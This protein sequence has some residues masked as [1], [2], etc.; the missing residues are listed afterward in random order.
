MPIKT[1][2][3]IYQGTVHSEKPHEFTGILKLLFGGEVTSGNGYVTYALPGVGAWKVYSDVG[4]TKP[5]DHIPLQIET[6]IAATVEKI[7]Q[8]APP[9][10]VLGEEGENHYR[11][12][13][14]KSGGVI[15]GYV[16]LANR[17]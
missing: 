17:S 10:F 7:R 8:M 12:L 1:H 15:I 14:F 16:H 11:R 6:N 3:D 4:H 5:S 2:S 9:L 13:S